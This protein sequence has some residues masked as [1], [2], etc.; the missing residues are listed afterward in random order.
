MRIFDI[1]K[2]IELTNPDLVTGKLIADKLLLAHHEA[3]EAV[4]EKTVEQIAEKIVLEGGKVIEVNNKKYKVLQEYANGGRVVQEIV[5]IPSSPAREA[6][7]DYEDIYVYI[8]YTAAELDEINKQNIRTQ[9]AELCFPIVNRGMLWYER[10]TSEQYTDLAL[11]YQA[12]LDAP[13]T[14]VMP[15]TPIWI[16]Q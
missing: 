10:L 15:E 2:T 4:Y 12:W 11:W 6:Y 13:A 3:V 14:G 9:R 16:K 7:D 5:A 8:P 1:T